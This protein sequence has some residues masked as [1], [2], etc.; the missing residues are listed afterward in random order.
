[1]NEDCSPEP[2]PAVVLCVCV[3]AR[4]CVRASERE[5]ETDQVCLREVGI[6]I[7]NTFDMNSGLQGLSSVLFLFVIDVRIPG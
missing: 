2:H 3:R 1:V 4:A 6:E 7:L 5:R